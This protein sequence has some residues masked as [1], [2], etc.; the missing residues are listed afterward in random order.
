MSMEFKSLIEDSNKL[1]E[2]LRA[3]TKSNDVITEQ[4]MAKMEGEL[5]NVLSAKSAL[6]ARLNAMETAAAR[7]GIA[8]K[9]AEVVDEYKAAFIDMLRFPNDH[10]KKSLA[11][12]LAVKSV[13]IG[14]GSAGGFAVPSQIAAD[15]ARIAQDYSPMRQL[16]SVVSVSTSDYVELLD[17]ADAGIEWIGETAARSTTTSPT[18]TQ[19]APVWGECAASVQISL[20]ALEDMAFSAEAWLTDSLAQKFATAEGAAFINGTGAKPAGI[21]T[22][23]LGTVKTGAAATLG[24]APADALMDLSY[25][26]KAE[27]RNGACF[28]MNSTTMATLAKT[29][30]TTGNYILVTSLVAGVAPTLLGKPVYVDENM[31]AIGA[32]AKPVLFGDFR[33]GYLIADRIGFG[34]LADPYSSTGFLTLKARKR[35]GGVAKDTNAV[36]ALIVQA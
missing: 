36:K 11:Q 28:L 21:L 18:L 3:E 24:A 8:G 29:K 14:T 19:I 2:A 23:A 35:V 6:E 12:S 13:N 7:P 16:A 31:P 20:S 34:V 22:A 10:A 5:A 1:I 33:R 26:V 25:A 17:N 30:D 15:V 27:Y 4:K 32:G 9:S